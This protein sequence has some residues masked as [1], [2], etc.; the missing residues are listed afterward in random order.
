MFKYYTEENIN[1]QKKTEQFSRHWIKLMKRINLVETTE[2]VHEVLWEQ[3]MLPEG[4]K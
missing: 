2:L 1:K 4:Y 3:P